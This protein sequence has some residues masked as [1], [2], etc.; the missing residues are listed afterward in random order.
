[1][2]KP[3][4]YKLQLIAWRKRRE[5]AAKLR[6]N[7]KTLEEIGAVIGC[8]RERVRQLLLKAQQDAC[9]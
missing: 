6:A 4:R 5:L 8:T 9:A 3:T 2:N 7:G 1:M